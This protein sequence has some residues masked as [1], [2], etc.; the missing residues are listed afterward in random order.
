MPTIAFDSF[1]AEEKRIFLVDCRRWM[2]R[3]EDFFVE[4]EDPDPSAGPSGS[5]RREVTVVYTPTGK[6]RVYEAG[7]GLR[8]LSSFEDDLQ[9]GYFSRAWLKALKG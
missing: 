9:V 3:P 7:I 5:E 2:R 8:W 4:A 6:G 1:P